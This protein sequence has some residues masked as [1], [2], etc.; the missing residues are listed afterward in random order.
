MSDEH[1]ERC[2]CRE[3]L[4]AGKWGDDRADSSFAP[5]TLL[6]VFVVNQN[7]S[8]EHEIR[9]IY[10]TLDAAN[11]LVDRIGPTAWITE[12]KLNEP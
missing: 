8:Y 1:G 7:I 12:H 2:G 9:G 10:T 6:K 4:Q 11:S 5:A 3:C